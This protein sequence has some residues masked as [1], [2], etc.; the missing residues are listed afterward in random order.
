MLLQ[1][2][3]VLIGVRVARF[4]SR[5]DGLVVGIGNL[6]SGFASGIELLDRVV[7]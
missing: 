2:F 6:L 1:F 4:D 7:E 5:F 3:S